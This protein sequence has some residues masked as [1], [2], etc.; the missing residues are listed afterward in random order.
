VEVD[1]ALPPEDKK[2]VG[3]LLMAFRPWVLSLFSKWR[4]Q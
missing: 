1:S 2:A 4:R 3:G